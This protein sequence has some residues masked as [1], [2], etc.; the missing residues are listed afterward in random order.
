MNV[1]NQSQW[2]EFSVFRTRVRCAINVAD[3]MSH[4]RRIGE[5]L[6]ITI[7]VVALTILV[8]AIGD[9]WYDIFDD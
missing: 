9:K 2:L 3:M 8:W 5:W 7:L 4:L 6:M 1:E